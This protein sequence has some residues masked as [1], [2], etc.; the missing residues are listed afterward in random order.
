MFRCRKVGCPWNCNTGRNGSCGDR[1]LN[2][3]LGSV[4][5]LVLVGS[6]VLGVLSLV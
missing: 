1:L 2:R 5:I 3:G 6:F 4:L